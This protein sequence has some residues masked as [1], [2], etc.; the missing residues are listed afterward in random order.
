VSASWTLAEV[1]RILYRQST[2]ANGVDQL[3][4]CGIRPDPERHDRDRGNR[5]TGALA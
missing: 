1:L 3:K 5:E 4:D 2:H